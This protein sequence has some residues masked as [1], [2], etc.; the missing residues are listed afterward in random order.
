MMVRSMGAM[1]FLL[2]GCAVDA[3]PATSDTPPAV[4][5]LMP[6]GPPATSP[7]GWVDYCRRHAADQGCG[8]G[9]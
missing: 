7:A 5:E 8:T 6:A 4:P 1:A 3:P 9:R 2:A